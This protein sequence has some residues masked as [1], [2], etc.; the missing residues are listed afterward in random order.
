MPSQMPVEWYSFDWQSAK[1]EW[2]QT[3]CF[4][5]NFEQLITILLPAYEKKQ[6][7]SYFSLKQIDSDTYAV[8]HDPSKRRCVS[9]ATLTLHRYTIFRVNDHLGQVYHE[10][11]PFC[12]GWFA[13]L[14]EEFKAHPFERYWQKANEE[15]YGE[16]GHW[17][18]F[19]AYLCL[20]QIFN[21]WRLEKQLYR[22]WIFRCSK[23]LSDAGDIHKLIELHI[24]NPNYHSMIA[25]RFAPALGSNP[26]SNR[27][28]NKIKI[29]GQIFA[30]VLHIKADTGKLHGPFEGAL[31]AQRILQWKNTPFP[32]SDQ[33]GTTIILAVCFDRSLNAQYYKMTQ[34]VRYLETVCGYNVMRFIFADSFDSQLLAT[35]KQTDP[36]LIVF[37]GHGTEVISP[38]F[39]PPTFITS[40]DN[41]DSNTLGQFVKQLQSNT[42][43]ECVVFDCCNIGQL[44]DGDCMDPLVNR[45]TNLF[46]AAFQFLKE[47]GDDI[48]PYLIENFAVTKCSKMKSNPKYLNLAQERLRKDF[49]SGVAFEHIGKH[50][51]S[52]QDEPTLND[53]LIS[54]S[55]GKPSGISVGDYHSF[56]VYSPTFRRVFKHSLY[57]STQS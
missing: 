44:L 50:F 3:Q 56:V 35:C 4:F 52:F 8:F 23:L 30:P 1:P 18:L 32:N 41:M 20:R 55:I 57:Q 22:E 37:I 28:S 12:G 31:D 13:D 49:F 10:Y 46:V 38:D 54:V 51:Q 11:Y 45:E 53:M 40:N 17:P 9:I 29:N 27:L 2:K 26:H 5:R 6:S 33:L 24:D 48:I 25:N 47:A 42:R 19:E 15:I 16:P 14:G 34:L 7:F 43:L 39:T 21:Q 36:R